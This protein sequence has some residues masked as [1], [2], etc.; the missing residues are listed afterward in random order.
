MGIIENQHIAK[1][2]KPPHLRSN[3]NSAS[4]SNEFMS[5]FSQKPRT[6][7]KK[8]RARG[9]SWKFPDIFGEQ[10]WFNRRSTGINE[11]TKPRNNSRRNSGEAARKLP[12]PS[13]ATVALIAVTI[14]IAFIALKWDDLNI[15]TP[16]L[17]TFRVL[18]DSNADQHTITYAATGISNLLP[19]ISTPENAVPE[20]T[21]LEEESA[22]GMLVTFEWQQYRVQR[23]DVVSKIAEK[24]DVSIGAIIASNDITNVRR[25]PEGKVIR[26]PNIDGIPYQI[27]KGDTLSK[28]A[29][30]FNVPLDVILD[31][32][33]IQSDV[34][35]AGETIFI[36]GGR[37]NDIDLRKSLGDLFMFP[38]QNRFI[39]S[40]YGMRKDPINGNL[41]FHSGVDFRGNIGTPVMASLDGVVSVVGENWLYGKY[42]IISHSNGYKTLYGHL[43]SFNVKQGDRVAR[44]RKIGEVGNTGYSTGPH[45]HFGMYDR[46]NRLINPLELLN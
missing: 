11:G 17:Y 24:F 9:Q 33:D 35:N 27:K 45:L 40:R 5:L 43:N 44:G 1:R 26:I 30:S 22:H 46:N 3:S 15:Q 8:K 6:H 20:S 41:Q 16:D 21:P 18:E 38:L 10:S 31:V 19:S 14:L 42:I 12:I 39:T 28:I 2:R 36:P 25:L 13:L 32:N 29:A 7:K 37:M 4:S 23:G 34:I